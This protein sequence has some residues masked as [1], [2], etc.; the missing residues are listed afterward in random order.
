MVGI[1][2]RLM[3]KEIIADIKEVICSIFELNLK[4]PILVWLSG[5]SL[6]VVSS[7]IEEWVYNDI[8]VY[9]FIVSLITIDAVLA[10]YIAWK[11]DDVQTKKLPIFAWSLVAQTG[12]ISFATTFSRV[13]T[14]FWLDDA[15]VAPIVLVNLLSVIKHLS[16]LGYLPKG[17]AEILYKKI[18]THKNQLNG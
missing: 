10:I 13:D 12:L 8:R 2:F 18:D 9:L 16:I 7:F 17:L 5:I 15:V 14:L 1:K 3:K 4:K 11:N 6:G